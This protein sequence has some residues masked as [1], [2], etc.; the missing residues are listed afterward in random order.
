MNAIIRTKPHQRGTAAYSKVGAARVPDVGEDGHHKAARR[1]LEKNGWPGMWVPGQHDS[2]PDVVVWV[3]VCRQPLD[4]D[5]VY[6]EDGG[7][8]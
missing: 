7:A 8:P 5:G 3:Y 1:L 6:I 2:E 4:V